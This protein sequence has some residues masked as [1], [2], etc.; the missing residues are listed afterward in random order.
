MTNVP[1]RRNAERGP[2]TNTESIM[3]TEATPHFTRRRLLLAAAVLAIVGA[4]VIALAVNTTSSDDD[5]TKS[6]A[7]AT[8]VAPITVAR[9]TTVATQTVS[10]AVEGANDIPVTFTTPE[11]WAGVDGWSAHSGLG[12]D[13]ALVLFDS[14][15]NIYTDGCQWKLVD[16]PV[17]PTVDDLVAA[18]AD[19]P[20][21]AATAA[22]DVTVDGYAAKQIEFTVP[23]YT[24]SDCKEQ[25]FGVYMVDG[26]HPPG[27]WAFFPDQ[28]FQMSVLDVDGT[29]LLIGAITYPNTSPQDRA[30][31]EEVLASIRIG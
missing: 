16:P 8:T 12:D 24:P 10:F 25:K 19:V 28:H 9:T 1:R 29:R 11:T 23:D 5:Q 7:A 13:G 6:P 4:T 22:V 20:E 27:Q 31:L 17:G 26:A 15:S 3:L 30:A 14:V 2:D 18:W 21:L